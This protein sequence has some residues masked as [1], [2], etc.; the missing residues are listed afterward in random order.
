MAVSRS[1]GT[2]QGLP[3]INGEYKRSAGSLLGLELEVRG[4]EFQVDGLE[5]RIGGL[6]F[7]F[8]FR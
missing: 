6:E 2:S 4:L 1:Q 5:F 3:D 7:W 8:C